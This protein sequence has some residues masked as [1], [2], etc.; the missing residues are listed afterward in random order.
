[1]ITAIP[2][3]N[4][5]TTGHGHVR[6]ERPS[7]SECRR[8][9]EHPG[10][11]PHEDDRIGSVAGTIGTSTTVM[12]PVGPDDLHVRAAED[13]G[14]EPATI[15]VIEPRVGAEPGGDPERQGQRQRHDTDRD[16]RD[17]VARAR[18]RPRPA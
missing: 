17:D 1:M 6:Q 10:E 8:H 4:P 15:A 18:T 2:T 3:V 5:S 7:R 13:A 12:A 16:A 9:D 14:D 11:D